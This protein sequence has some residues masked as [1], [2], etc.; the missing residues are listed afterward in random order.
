MKYRIEEVHVPEYKGIANEDSEGRVVKDLADGSRVRRIVH[1]FGPVK[2][3]GN[4]VVLKV[5]TE[6]PLP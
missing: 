6:A 1:V 5:L 2:E 3:S 4:G